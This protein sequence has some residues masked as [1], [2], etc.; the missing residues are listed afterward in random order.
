MTMGMVYSEFTSYLPP[1]YSFLATPGL[2][3]KVDE[4]KEGDLLGKGC[5]DT[6]VI[7][8]K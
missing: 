6:L 5:S 3:A 4:F 8:A 7:L 1:G 2:L